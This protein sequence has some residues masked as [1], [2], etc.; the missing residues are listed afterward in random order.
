MGVVLFRSSSKCHRLG[1]IVRVFLRFSGL[2]AFLRGEG[3]A[4]K[5]IKLAAGK[6]ED[7]LVLCLI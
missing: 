5:Q 2:I 1:V 7:H 4:A 6:G 3:R